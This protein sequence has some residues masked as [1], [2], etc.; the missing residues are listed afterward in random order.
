MGCHFLRQ[1]IFPTQGS[2]P[3]LFC[4]LHGP[5]GSLPLAPPGKPSLWLGEFLKSSFWGL[6]AMSEVFLRIS[7]AERDSVEQNPGIHEGAGSCGN[8]EPSGPGAVLVS[9]LDPAGRP[10]ARPSSILLPQT[11][12]HA[13]ALT[14]NDSLNRSTSASRQREVIVTLGN[15]TWAFFASGTW[16]ESR[17]RFARDQHLGAPAPTHS[18]TILELHF[19]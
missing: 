9:R 14:H 11:H 7:N 1:G 12:T 2:N 6:W 5:A 19:L 4:L 8:L 16:P 3:H 13:R 18:C 17:M 10:G 15:E